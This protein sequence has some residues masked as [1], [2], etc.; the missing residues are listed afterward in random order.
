MKS[1]FGYRAPT[2]QGPHHHQY[3]KGVECPRP[4][5]WD[6]GGFELGH[7]LHGLGARYTRMDDV[8]GYWTFF[9]WYDHD[10]DTG[11]HIQ[12]RKDF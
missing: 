7:L 9:N 3:N 4:N 1:T 2:V 12:D 5:D 6:D 10:D 11:Q 8:L